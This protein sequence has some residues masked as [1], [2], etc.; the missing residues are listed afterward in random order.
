MEERVNWQIQPR[1]GSG[2]CLAE[3]MLIPSP[4]A[5][6]FLQGL[7][8][9]GG[10]KDGK[11]DMRPFTIVQGNSSHKTCLREKLMNDKLLIINRIRLVEGRVAG[12]RSV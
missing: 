11:S 4:L 2:L 9:E 12:N 8:A 7:W 5:P 6:A 1:V 10:K 3:V